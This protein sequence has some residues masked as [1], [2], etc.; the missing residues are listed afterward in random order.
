MEDKIY[1]KSL[2]PDLDNELNKELNGV[3]KIDD[4]SRVG[5][6]EIEQ[7]RPLKMREQRKE[8]PIKKERKEKNSPYW[9]KPI[10]LFAIFVVVLFSVLLYFDKIDLTKETQ[11][12]NESIN[13]NCAPN[14]EC[15]PCTNTCDNECKP[16]IVCG[17]FYM[18]QQYEQE[19]NTTTL[20]ID[21]LFP[22]ESVNTTSIFFEFETNLDLSQA[23][24]EFN[25]S[26]YTMDGLE[27][28][29]NTTIEIVNGTHTYRGWGK[30]DGSWYNTEELEV[31]K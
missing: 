25:N 29:W 1:N 4:L 28:R 26:N 9:F 6:K 16:E 12:S 17:S 2:I 11:G 22:E 3:G 8:R 20:T 18:G 13:L 5:K 31:I 19:T 27:R 21:F 24:L 30:R 10:I 15:P 7:P 14:I 23:I